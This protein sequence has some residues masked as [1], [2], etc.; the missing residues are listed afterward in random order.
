MARAARA[1]SAHAFDRRAPGRGARRLRPE[2]ALSVAG[3]ARDPHQRVH[4]AVGPLLPGRDRLVPGGSRAG[5]RRPGGAQLLDR[6]RVPAGRA[7]RDAGTRRD[8]SIRLVG[9]PL[10]RGGRR[11]ARG[12]HFEHRHGGS[13]G[14]GRRGLGSG[15]ARPRA[16]QGGR[17]RR[18]PAREHRRGHERAERDQ[19][20]E[21]RGGG[22]GRGLRRC[23]PLPRPP[24]AHRF[25]TEPQRPPAACAW[26][27][28][29]SHPWAPGRCPA[30]GRTSTRWWRRAAGASG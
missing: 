10:V 15:P 16:A 11:R 7:H 27:P 17:P 23:R 25:A 21:P 1:L 12:Q 19:G 30:P 24:G 4:G 26:W 20:R 14:V 2:P 28:D 18:A 6:A 8:A 3:A 13:A 5:Q 9:A 22:R 29:G